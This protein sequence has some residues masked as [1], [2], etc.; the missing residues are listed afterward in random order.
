MHTPEPLLPVLSNEPVAQ[1][2][3]LRRL[4]NITLAII[5]FLVAL[6]LALSIAWFHSASCSCTPQSSTPVPD[7]TS[8]RA[9][10]TLGQYLQ[11]VSEHSYEKLLALF[12]EDSVLENSHEALRGLQAIG[13]YYRNGVLSYPT[14]RPEPGPFFIRNDTIAIQ[15][16][17]HLNDTLSRKVG[18][19]FQVDGNGKISKLFVYDGQ[20]NVN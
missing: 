10:N 1:L 6:I 2:A 16:T 3:R 19:W 5:V 15:I 4:L 14:F 13:N 11:A 7:P 9:Q 17:L 20:V 8:T 12:S 18:D